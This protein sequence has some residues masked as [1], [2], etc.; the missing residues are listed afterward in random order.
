[1]IKRNSITE[2][3]DLKSQGAFTLIQI[4]IVI[5]LV[6]VLAITAVSFLPSQSKI[7]LDAATKQ[8]VAHIQVAQQN[9]VTTTVTSGVSFVNGGAYTA[10]QGTTATPI[11]NPQTGQNL[12]IT[13]SATYP[14][15][16]LTKSYTVEFNSMGTP[17]TG[18]GGNITISDG[19]TTK[20][21]TVSANVGRVTV[22]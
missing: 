14:G 16:S 2:R 20:T 12:I 17:T 11:K 10:Y 8:V 1:M 7:R 22:Q 5:A 18:G 15:I 6:G 9:A 13:L 21:V 19:T 4:V 3:Q